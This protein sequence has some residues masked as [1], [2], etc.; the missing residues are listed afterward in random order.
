MSKLLGLLALFVL[1]APTMAQASC[2]LEDDSVEGGS[3]LSGGGCLYR[4]RTPQSQRIFELFVP[5]EFDGQLD[6]PVV[7]DFHGYGMVKAVQRDAS[8]WRDTAQRDNLLV[9]YPQA[10]GFPPAFF[11]G[12]YCCYIS[13]DLTPRDD[14]QYARDIVA[15]MSRLAPKLGIDGSSIRSYASGLSNGGAMAHELACE[16]NDLFGGVAAVSQTFTKEPGNSCIESD[17]TPIPVLDV[18]GRHDTMI[19]YDGGPSLSTLYSED[20]LSAEESRQR[21]REALDC[22]P[23]VT[24]TNYDNETSGRY[25]DSYFRLAQPFLKVAEQ[26]TSFCVTMEGCR[27]DFVQCSINSGHSPYAAAAAS[28]VDVCAA[29]LQ[30]FGE[31]SDTSP[32][33]FE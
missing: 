3:E 5:D 11:A 28:G 12:D 19:P 15:Q 13:V 18:R 7:L 33:V 16:A 21:W 14:V 31:Y 2:D 6:P 4:V 17:E 1:S 8:C 10:V 24:V 23:Y 30:M 20:W 9:V 25:L 29:A 22:G 26:D 27:A 32:L